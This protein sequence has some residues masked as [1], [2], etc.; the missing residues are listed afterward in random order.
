M[1]AAEWAGGLS[2]TTKEKN[3]RVNLKNLM[4]SY[5]GGGYFNP[6]YHD[7]ETLEIDRRFVVIYVHL[8]FILL[9]ADV[10]ALLL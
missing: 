6:A 2:V 1:A 3:Q 8:Y 9:Y 4:T 10:T 5:D 7:S